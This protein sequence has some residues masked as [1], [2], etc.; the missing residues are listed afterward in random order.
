MTSKEKFLMLYLFTRK[1]RDA[2]YKKVIGRATNVRAFALY[3]KLGATNMKEH[4]FEKDGKPITLY[5]FEIDLY[6]EDFEK[7]LAMV[8]IKQNSK[9]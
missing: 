4:Q 1:L 9:L 2:G 3:K 6:N 7:I 5:W 8:P